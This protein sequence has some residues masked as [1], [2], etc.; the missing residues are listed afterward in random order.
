MTIGV[1]DHALL[2]FLSRA[3]GFD[4]E[5]LRKQMQEALTEASAA[6]HALGQSRYTV[7]MDGMIFVVENGVCVTMVAKSERPFLLQQERKA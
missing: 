2:R 1:S 4:L 3:G 7:K 5:T 6:A